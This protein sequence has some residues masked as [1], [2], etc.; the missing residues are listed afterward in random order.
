MADV[1]P[2]VL[3]TA[4]MSK[5]LD[6]LTNGDEHVPKSADNFFAWYTPGVPIGA[7]DLDY[8]TQGLTGV[9]KKADVE[10]LKD[11]ASAGATSTGGTSGST[12]S[13]SASSGLQMDK[14]T[15]DTLRATDAARM[16]MQAESFARLVDV[17]PEVSNMNN[18]LATI[19]V[20]NNEGTLSE[21]YERIL[22]MSQVMSQALPADVVK[23]IE[24]FRGL[25]STTV[26]KKDLLDDTAPPKT[27]TEP[28]ELTKAY[29]AKMAAYDAAALQYNSHR[30]DALAGDDPK[31]VHYW[32]INANILRDQVRA[33]MEDWINSGFKEDYEKIAAYIE[34]VQARDLSLLKAQYKDDLAKAKLT[35]LSSGSDFYYTSVVPGDFARVGGWSGFSFGST[36]FSSRSNSQLSSSRS[37]VSGGGGFLFVAA[38]GSHS[39]GSSHQEFHGSFSSDVFSLSF[40]ICQVPI[41][42]PW[43]KPSF[44]VSKTWRFDPS[45]PDL[46]G[47]MV[48]DGGSPSKGLMP[49]FPTTAV[50]IRNL[51]LRIGHS[52]GFNDFVANARQSSSG[53]GG[54]LALGPFSFGAAASASSS[55]SNTRSD[56]GYHWDGQ[57]MTVN[58]MQ[59][60]GFKC[61]VFPKSP[62]PAPEIKEWV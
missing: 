11:A 43:F 39:E 28:S 52:N 41:V 19:N 32:A 14:A 60:A 13:G 46:K 2:N 20:Q 62:N 54:F 44:I 18:R 26:Q 42:R 51:S 47:D 50:F 27:V 16:Y 40:E 56:F 36:D 8:L 57:S 1:A 48:S 38:A 29:F 4:I 9:V 12:S 25:I 6:V 35:G 37:S 15:L 7:D 59:L 22:T 55:S 53:G 5:L 45:I 10:V 21:I 33:A 49:A 17:V 3:S 58:G 30:I 61:H 31:A 23:K 34:Q 24:K